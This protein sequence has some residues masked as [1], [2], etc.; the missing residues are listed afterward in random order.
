[1]PS[2]Y[3]E[4]MLDEYTYD[5]YM[6]EE[7]TVPESVNVYEAVVQAN[8]YGMNIDGLIWECEST[9]AQ[10][11]LDFFEDAGVCESVWDYW[12][13]NFKAAGIL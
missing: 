7:Y 8:T 3:T 10:K 13:G 12:A 5:L 1:M 11:V 9:I 2:L 4:S 6:E